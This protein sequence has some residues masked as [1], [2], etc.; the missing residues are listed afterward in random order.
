MSQYGGHFA[1]GPQLAQ[2]P[3]GDVIVAA[4][5]DHAAGGVPAEE[6]EGVWDRWSI[7]QS[8]KLLP[9]LVHVF[10]DLLVDVQAFTVFERGD[11]AG[12]QHPFPRVVHLD[13]LLGRTPG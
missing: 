6:P 10:R 8:R 2:E 5:K 3:D 4:R 11:E 12:P 9:D 7:R 13:G 1:L